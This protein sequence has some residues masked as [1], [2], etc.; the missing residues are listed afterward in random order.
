VNA[1]NAGLRMGGGVC[2]AIFNAAGSEKLQVACDRYGQ[3][4][5]GQAVITDG[6]ALPS[7]FIIHTVGPI[8][9]GDTAGEEQTLRDCY[10]N[11]L[12][13]AA[14]HQLTSIAF[15]LISSGIFGYPVDQALQVALAAITAFLLEH[16]MDVYLVVFDKRSFKLSGQLYADVKSYIDETLVDTYVAKNCGRRLSDEMEFLSLAV[17]EPSAV[18]LYND[19]P[20]RERSLH[21]LVAQLEES[22]SQMVFRFIA[23]KGLSEVETYRRANI[24]RKLFS[25]IRSDHDYNPKKSTAIALAI[26]LELNVDETKDLLARAGY[27]LSRSH[28]SDVIIEYF[29]SNGLFNVYE[30]N[31]ALFAFDQQLLGA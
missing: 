14:Q 21:D 20:I 17:Q 9:T 25:K 8:W 5:P 29:I 26:A 23:E 30:I 15:P 18:E 13:V 6:F 22:F 10:T 16:D 27:T 3:C 1:A 31:E 24:D 28:M 19:I 2:G 7:R 12:K 11:S 4:A